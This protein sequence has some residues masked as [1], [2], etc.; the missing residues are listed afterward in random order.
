MSRG[1]YDLLQYRLNSIWQN[2]EIEEYHNRKRMTKNELQRD[3]T[4]K[5]SPDIEQITPG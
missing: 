3:L 5:R 2:I 1:S 4:T